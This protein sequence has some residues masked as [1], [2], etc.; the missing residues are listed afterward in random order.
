MSREE[1][2]ISQVYRMC[3]SVEY[4]LAHWKRSVPLFIVFFF[5]LLGVFMAASWISVSTSTTDEFDAFL[6]LKS[7]N[8]LTFET[9]ALMSMGP[10]WENPDYALTDK[11]EKTYMM[12]ILLAGTYDYEYTV[13]TGSFA[14]VL[15]PFISII[16]MS[17]IL[18]TYTNLW[19]LGKKM[20]CRIGSTSKGVGALAG[21]GGTAG[22]IFS[23]LLMA[24]CCG[25]TGISF[26]LFSLPVVGIGFSSFYSGLDTWAT[27]VITIP[28]TITLLVLIV[29]MSSKLPLGKDDYMTNKR[30]GAGK[31]F[32][33]AIY[34]IV[35][36]F[37][38]TV[39]GVMVYWWI[40]QAASASAAGLTGGNQDLTIS[41][42]ATLPLAAGIL[43]V[44][45]YI[46]LGKFTHGKPSSQKEEIEVKTA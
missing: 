32:K 34:L 1:K 28:S 29:F 8:Y 37:F 36:G 40:L 22:G 35:P 42:F 5:G 45:A 38:L 44:G 26:L 21:S 41:V 23:M 39:F 15:G 43:L 20:G 9:G 31:A 3:Y 46:T 12:P 13:L 6:D 2:N 7:L 10:Y 25:I 11:I 33:I 16:S 14:I 19:L 30:S 17:I 18:S 24:G 27:T 4:S